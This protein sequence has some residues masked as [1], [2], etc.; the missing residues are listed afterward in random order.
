MIQ[1]GISYVIRGSFKTEAF[2]RCLLNNI[3]LYCIATGKRYA[4]HHIQTTPAAVPEDRQP[5]TQTLSPQPAELLL[6]FEP[7]LAF[8]VNFKKEKRH[9]V[10]KADFTL[11][12]DDEDSMG[13]N[14]VVVEAKCEGTA[15][16]AARQLIAYMGR[17]S[18]V[19]DLASS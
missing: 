8:P 2:A 11:W 10:G 19:R 5:R 9:L 3:V 13:T 17:I 1:S 16:L 4:E 7:E 6:R 18:A 15:S 12:Y 14:L